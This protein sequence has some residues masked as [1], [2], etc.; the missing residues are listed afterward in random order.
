MQSAIGRLWPLFSFGKR[1]PASAEPLEEG[2]AAYQRGDYAAALKFLRPLAKQNNSQAQYTL[3]YMYAE[4]E[5][6]P[7]HDGKAAKLYRKAAEQGDADAQN[8]LGVMYVAGRG[9]PADDAEAMKWFRKAAEQGLREAQYNLGLMNYIGEGV[10][11]D[12]VQAHMWYNIADTLGDEDAQNG[13]DI[14]AI[15]MTPDQV[16]EAERLAR[17]W[18]AKHQRS[19]LRVVPP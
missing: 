6:V 18:I 5:G 17:E 15:K 9:V 2:M 12:L 16:T 13:R 11:Q 19:R 4:G 14:A 8:E 1:V 3:G 7:E 10:P